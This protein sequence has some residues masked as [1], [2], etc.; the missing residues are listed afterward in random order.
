[1]ENE[2]KNALNKRA[3]ELLRICW[4]SIDLG[5]DVF[6]QKCGDYFVSN[7]DFTSDS[8]KVELL[9]LMR[10]RTDFDDFLRSLTGGICG[11]EREILATYIIDTTGLLLKAAVEFLEERK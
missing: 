11:P 1:M 7:P 5:E 4:H 6:C 2:E 9:R 8:G 10:K 3:C